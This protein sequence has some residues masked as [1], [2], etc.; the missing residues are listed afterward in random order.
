MIDLDAWEERAAIMEFCGGLPRF[1]AETYAAHAQ[2]LRR[3][4]VLNAI[5]QRDLARARD[6]GAQVGGQSRPD[7]LPSVQP[8]AEEEARPV[9]ERHSNA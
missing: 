8:H 7:G 4:E 3:D 2:G 5:R 1:K 6:R 9:P